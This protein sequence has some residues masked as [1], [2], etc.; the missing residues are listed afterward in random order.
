MYITEY[1]FILNLFAQEIV[2][3][4]FHLY[5]KNMCIIKKL[6]KIQ[7]TDMIYTSISNQNI[8]CGN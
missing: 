6:S 2:K 7:L 8:Q 3:F 4:Y 1:K 5:L